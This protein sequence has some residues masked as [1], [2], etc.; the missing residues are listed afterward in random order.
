MDSI[1]KALSD[2][3]WWFTVIIVGIFVGIIG[4]LLKDG[5]KSAVPQFIGRYRQSKQA[6]KA[7]D[8][9]QIDF[10][11]SHPDVMRL[12]FADLL[13]Q[14]SCLILLVIMVVGF[15]SF[16][17]ALETNPDFRVIRILP[18]NYRALARFAGLVF[19]VAWAAGGFVIW[20]TVRRY[21]LLTRAFEKFKRE[22]SSP[23]E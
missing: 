18:G 5:L 3:S 21:I 16:I 14:F 13:I 4:G 8:Q 6:R 23:E 10:W 1:R 17:A 12:E 11:V 9:Q 2:P 22:K 7:A 15:P 19:V 20:N